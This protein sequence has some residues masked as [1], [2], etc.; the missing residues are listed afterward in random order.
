MAKKRTP[1]DRG[2]A[3]AQRQLKHSED[4]Q[5]DRYMIL[6]NLIETL[7]ARREKKDFWKVDYTQLFDMTSPQAR[8]IATFIESLYWDECE[9]ADELHAIMEDSDAD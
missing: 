3:W 5:A 1:L 2:I 8:E 7:W 9:A 6:C 4:R